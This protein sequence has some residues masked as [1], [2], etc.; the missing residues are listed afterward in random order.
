MGF[1]IAR[2]AVDA[3]ALTTLITGPVALATPDGV[4]RV[5]VTSAQEMHEASLAQIQHC[6]IFIGCAAVAD[7][8]PAHSEL[9]KIKKNADTMHLE[10]VRNPDIISAVANH[11]ERPFTV[12][13]AA[14]TEEVESYARAKLE[15]K[16]LDMVVANDVSRPEGGFNSDQNAAIILWPGG[17]A[18]VKLT[19][20][21][22]LARI[23]VETIA[24]R[25]QPQ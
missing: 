18:E 8:R 19:T 3:G 23:L 17:K 21:Q 1:A 7:Y 10:L 20:K 11:P 22:Q 15:N 16:K 4:Q 13:F 12:G 5:D 2:A 9:Q 24:A 25:C 14:E 6:D